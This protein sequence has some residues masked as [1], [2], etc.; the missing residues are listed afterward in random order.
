MKSRKKQT[1]SVLSIIASVTT[2]TAIMLYAHSWV[3]NKVENHD[4]DDMDNQILLK[5]I[6]IMYRDIDQVKKTSISTTDK[7]RIKNDLSVSSKIY[8]HINKN[9]K[10]KNNDNLEKLNSLIIELT[11]SINTIE[12]KEI[13]PDDKIDKNKD[14]VDLSELEAKINKVSQEIDKANFN[15]WIENLDS[16]SQRIEQVDKPLY[17]SK[18]EASNNQKDRDLFDGLIA[19]NN[20]NINKILLKYRE[21]AKKDV[22]DSQLVEASE[23]EEILDKINQA[24]TVVEIKKIFEKFIFTEFKNNNKKRIN[25]LANISNTQKDL[26]N[27]SIE[28]SSDFTSIYSIVDSMEILN[29]YKNF[30][31]QEINRFRN[32]KDEHKTQYISRL[33][34]SQTLEESIRIFEEINDIENYKRKAL[35][36]IKQHFFTNKTLK[37]NLIQDILNARNKDEVKNYFTKALDIEGI[38]ND[39]YREF[40]DNYKILS[41]HQ[42]E[43][44]KRFLFDAIGNDDW[45]TALSAANEFWREL[46]KAHQQLQNFNNFSESKN[47]DIKRE[48]DNITST[49][50]LKS[51]ISQYASEHHNYTIDLNSLKSLTEFHDPEVIN[52]FLS[53]L[54]PD[55][56]EDLARVLKNARDLANKKREQ[57]NIIN[58]NADIGQ[59]KKAE[60]I[61]HIKAV[62]KPQGIE[63]NKKSQALETKRY[64]ALNTIENTENVENKQQFK[65]QISNST[66]IEEIEEVLYTSQTNIN[67]LELSKYKAKTTISKFDYISEQ[68]KIE[69]KSAV[70]QL[71]NKTAI[72]TKL[73]EFIQ[74]SSE[75]TEKFNSTIN[76][77]TLFDK[78]VK[79]DII[80]DF[81]FEK[82]TSVYNEEANNI[83]GLE[84]YK[85]QINTQ[86]EA[87]VSISELDKQS[88]KHELTREK[89]RFGVEV[90]LGDAT[91]RNKF[92][93]VH[94]RKVQKLESLD[95]STITKYINDMKNTTSVIQVQ[96]LKKDAYFL[97]EKSKHKLEIDNLNYLSDAEKDTFKR[98]VDRSINDSDLTSFANQ[99]TEINRRN[100][101]NA[102]I[103]KKVKNFDNLSQNLKD[104]YSNYSNNSID[105]NDLA[106]IDIDLSYIYETKLVNSPLKSDWSNLNANILAK[107]DNEIKNANYVDAVNEIIK[108]YKHLNENKTY[109]I[110]AINN[111]QNITEQQKQELLKLVDSVESD[112]GIQYIFRLTQ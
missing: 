45:T 68:E 2:T 87:L 73:Q 107:F 92:K 9:Q 49:E 47:V 26:I 11:K 81:I 53:T 89:S 65:D 17:Q 15:L 79:N 54:T 88:F 104:F 109:L 96:L 91:I 105:V 75:K 69:M 8:N 19:K 98:L 83:K 106:N 13:K 99:A 3:N 50:E 63:K 40:S 72:E 37:N 10:P 29:Y 51:T 78:D 27:S 62:S 64:Q 44:Y 97:N 82:N 36:T 38:R 95:E 86:I 24:K 23:K 55:D 61:A 39:I 111:E 21:K 103:I 74:K 25:E 1:I 100:R 77:I 31:T 66:T 41:Q 59:D 76:L 46:K 4:F 101:Y 52:Y 48:I 34:D 18:I 33:I 32:S 14:S 20:E 43:F 84:E 28:N 102:E 5:Q 112:A 58:N 16:N 94:I 12:D 110:N 35:G 42:K 22:L 7:D 60:L 108:K 70:V 30:A 93:E 85:K 90:V 71:N 6:N 57:I 80:D 67:E 56:S